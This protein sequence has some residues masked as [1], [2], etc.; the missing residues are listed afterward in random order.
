MTESQ[1]KL[2]SEILDLN[3]E[4][5]TSTDW[6]VKIELARKLSAKKKELATDMGQAAYD[7]FIE[8]GRRMF[9]PASH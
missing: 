4:F 9:A 8:T 5:E 1:S 3:W 6:T 7:E 2:F